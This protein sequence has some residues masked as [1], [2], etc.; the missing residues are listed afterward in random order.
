MNS[1]VMFLANMVVLFA[2]FLDGA[3]GIFWDII[4]DLLC[5]LLGGALF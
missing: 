3:V 4:K 1:F 5:C 2:R